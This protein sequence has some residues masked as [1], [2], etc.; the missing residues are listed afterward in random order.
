MKIANPKS[1]RE[2]RVIISDKPKENMVRPSKLVAAAPIY[3]LNCTYPPSKVKYTCLEN[4]N[5]LNSY[6][7]LFDERFFN[8]NL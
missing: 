3:V 7:I 4:N 5:F 1:E 2:L 6:E 8:L